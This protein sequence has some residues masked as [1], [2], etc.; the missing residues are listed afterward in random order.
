MG[1]V[2][3]AKDPTM[4]IVAYLRSCGMVGWAS[5][6]S[7]CHNGSKQRAEALAADN[8]ALRAR[9]A[10]VEGEFAEAKKFC[11]DAVMLVGEFTHMDPEDYMREGLDIGQMERALTDFLGGVEQQLEARATRAEARVEKLERVLA[12]IADTDPDEGT[13]WFH[14][15]AGAALAECGEGE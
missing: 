7:I 9:L 10:E 1:R 5:D 4:D 14:A 8:A 15:T 2:A 13:A 11:G 12:L 6:L 3:V